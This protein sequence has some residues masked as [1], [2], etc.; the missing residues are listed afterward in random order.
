MLTALLFSPDPDSH[1][2]TPLDHVVND[3]MVQVDSVIDLQVETHPDFT[4]LS[5]YLFSL[6][7]VEF[8]FSSQVSERDFDV[9]C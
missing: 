3:L 6:Q 4:L 2:N 8:P 9:K 1:Q 5:L 7:P